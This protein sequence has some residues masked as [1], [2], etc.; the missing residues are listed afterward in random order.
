LRLGLAKTVTLGSKSRR[1]HDHIL[2]S[3]LRL[4]QLG[5]PGPRIYIPPEQGGPVIPLGIGFPFVASYDSQGYRGGILTRLH[6]GVSHNGRWSLLHTLGTDCTENISSI[7]ACSLVAGEALFPQKC[8]LAIVVALSPVYIAV[9]MTGST[10]HY[11]SFYVA[12]I[13]VTPKLF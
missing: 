4:P 9:A 7:I 8:S 2:L 1:T 3:H 5:G 6:T 12:T 11:F 13:Y 10:S